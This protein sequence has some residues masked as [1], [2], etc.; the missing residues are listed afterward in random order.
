M[1]SRRKAEAPSGFPV[2]LTNAS[3][4]TSDCEWKGKDPEDYPHYAE[5]CRIFERS[6]LTKTELVAISHQTTASQ[7]TEQMGRPH[8]RQKSGVMAWIDANWDSVDHAIQ[9]GDVH[10]PRKK[11]SKSLRAADVKRKIKAKSDSRGH[12]RCCAKPPS[13]PTADAAGFEF[14]RGDSDQ[15]L[16]SWIDFD[17]F[18]EE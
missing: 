11:R 16:D 14:F 4:E 9:E 13:D 3:P 2:T 8:I 7:G 6:L 1:T 12:S 10:L 5:L 18:H 15:E 17:L